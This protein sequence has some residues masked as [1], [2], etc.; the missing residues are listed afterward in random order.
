[1]CCVPAKFI[2]TIRNTQLL[3]LDDYTF[4][5]TVP[6][7]RDSR[8]YSCTNKDCRSYVHVTNDNVIVTVCVKHNHPPTKF[9]KLE[10]G[11]YVKAEKYDDGLCCASLTKTNL[12]Q[13]QFIWTVRDTKLL[14]LDKYTFYKGGSVSKRGVRYVCT[15][16]KPRCKSSVLVDKDGMIASA[17]LNHTHPPPN[18][19]QMGD[20][21]YAKPD[22]RSCRRFTEYA[23][24]LGKAT[25]ITTG[26][27]TTKLVFDDNSFFKSGKEL[28][29][30][31]RRS[32]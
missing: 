2:T 17:Y 14:L 23:T 9:V 1:M 18:Y 11:R 22:M 32:S 29:D 8:R 16:N 19:I 6:I 28:I 30:G 10:D 25:F 5:K 7:A 26:R 15:H 27:G 12:G 13:A 4:Y 3:L 31:S 24:N 21:R 20:G